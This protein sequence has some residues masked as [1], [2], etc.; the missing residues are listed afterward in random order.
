MVA[1]LFS[2]ASESFAQ[3]ITPTGVDARGD[4]VLEPGKIEVFLNPGETVTK[5]ISVISRLAPNTR[6]QVVTEDFVGTQDPETPVL[7]LDDDSS[8]HSFRNNINPSVDNFS[9]DLGQRIQIP[10]T[11]TVPA[12][13]APGGYYSSVIV[14]SIPPDNASDVSAGRTRIV[15]RLGV[16]FFI[17]VNGP[18]NESGRLEDFRA[19][20]P[21]PGIIQNGPIT[22]EILYKNEG[23]VHLV[24][25]GMV[26]VRNIFGREVAAVP[27]DAYFSLPDSLRYRQVNWDKETLFGRYTA[28]LSLNRGYGDVVDEQKISFWAIPWKY[29]AGL[30]LVVFLVVTGMYLF[31]KKFELKRK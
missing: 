19:K 27:V 31:G 6:F 18:V 1:L 3:A 17:R 12:E 30:V 25:Y 7:L 10:V 26:K 14:A 11:I 2:A 20:G 5:N 29:V 8:P 23:S 9:L 28:T 15:S 13:T 4:F 16:L 24:P 21:K 22:F